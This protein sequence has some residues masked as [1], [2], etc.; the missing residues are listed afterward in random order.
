MTAFPILKLFFNII[1]LGEVIFWTGE[2]S[3]KLFGK[4]ADKANFPQAKTLF[5]NFNSK[6]QS[7]KNQIKTVSWAVLGS[8]CKWIG[9]VQ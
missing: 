2:G 1:Q 5:F 4:R 7:V 9:E 3:I 8:F 6:N